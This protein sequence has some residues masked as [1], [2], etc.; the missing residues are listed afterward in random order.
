MTPEAGERLRA[1]VHSIVHGAS[2]PLADADDLTEEMLG[3]LIERADAL[4]IGGAAEDDAIR[5]AIAD[6]GEVPAVSGE[7]GRTYHSRL[8]VSTVGVLLTARDGIPTPPGAVGA[9]RLLIVVEA[10]LWVA[11]G[12]VAL[13]TATPIHAV[14]MAA[15]SAV[16]VGAAVLAH[17][18]LRAGQAWALTFAIGLAFVTLAAGLAE[19]SHAPAGTT[20]ISLTAIAA[21]VILVWLAGSWEQ[22]RRFVAGSRSIGPRLGAALGAALIGPTLAALAIPAFADPTQASASDVDMTL[23]MTCGRRDQQIPDG[24]LVHDRQYAD[25]VVDLFW[26][27]SDVLPQ[28]LAGVVQSS[29]AGDTAGFRIIEPVPID[30]EN[31]GAMPSWMLDRPDPRVTVAETGEVAGW[32]G[33]TSPSVALIPDTMGSF[34]VGIEP[35]RIQSHRTIRIGWSLAP[36]EDGLQPWPR[37]EIAYAHLDRFVLIGSVGCGEKS[38]GSAKAT[39]APAQERFLP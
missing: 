21:A 16:F 36:T 17:R 15:A 33:S 39:P 14:V 25:L 5:T 19:M 34:T 20:T 8:W 2:V 18:G 29:G 23:A 9:L 27:R 35:D 32:F 11:L 26:R 6:F 7:L 28:G 3:H 31:G 1:H 30:I 37:A 13:L 24:P 22:A 38:S 4:M 12:A 10:L